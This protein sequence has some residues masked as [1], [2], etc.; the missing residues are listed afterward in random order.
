MGPL[1]WVSL[2]VAWVFAVVALYFHYRVSR[3]QIIRPELVWLALAW[4]TT[5]GVPL[6]FII[7]WYETFG[8]GK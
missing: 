3:W 8:F 2:L 7:A 4:L 1:S 6:L 5:I